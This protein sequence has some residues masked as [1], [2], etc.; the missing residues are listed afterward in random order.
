MKSYITGN[1]IKNLVEYC[2]QLK[3]NNNPNI[4][5]LIDRLDRE[6][7]NAKEYYRTKSGFGTE[8]I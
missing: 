1:E 2:L 8:S 6:F 5:E 3:E 7:R 4:K